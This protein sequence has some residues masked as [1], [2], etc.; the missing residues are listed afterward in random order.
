MGPISLADPD[1]SHRRAYGLAASLLL[2]DFNVGDLIRW[3][4]GAYTHEHIPMEPILTA[5]SAV[6]SIPPPE[7]YPAQDF[8]RALHILEHGAPVTASYECD[9]SDVRLRNAYD[10]HSTI[11]EHA[12]AVREKIISGA[13]NHFLLVLP[14]WIGRFIYGL[15]LSPIGFILRKHKGRIVVDPSTRI[16]S[17]AD[18]GALN[19]HMDKRNTADVPTTF[20]A[21]AQKRHWSHIWNLRASN[22]DTEILLYKDDINSAFHRGRYHPDIAAAFSY[23]WGDWLVISIGLIFGARNSPGWFC[24]LSELRAF[25]ATFYKDLQE[26]PLFQLVSRIVI[27]PAPAPEGP[28]TL[29]PA[30]RDVIN[31]GPVTGSEE[32]THHSTFVDDNLMAELAPRIQLAIQRS[33]AACYLLFGHPRKGILTPSLSEDKFVPAAA[34]HMEQLGFDVDT[35]AMTISYPAPKRSALLEI[36]DLGWTTGSRR[37]HKELAS[38]LGHVRTAAAIVP[39]GSYFS[40]RLQQWLNACMASTTSGVPGNLPYREAHK[41]AWKSKRNYSTPS[42]VARDIAYLRSLLVCPASASIWSRPIGLLVPRVPHMVSCTDASYEGLGGWSTEFDFQWRLS[43]TSLKELGWPVLTKE[44]APFRPLPK[45]MLH[46]N[47]L[48]FIAVFINTWLCMKILSTRT[49]PPGGWVLRLRADNT[50][51]LGWMGHPSR[52]RRDAIQHLARAYAALLTFPLPSSF[53]ITSDH[54]AGVANDAADALSRPQQFP[55]WASTRAKCP[56][57][58][59]LRAFRVPSKLL[60]HLLLSVSCTRTEETLERETTALLKLEPHTLSTGASAS[61]SPTSPSSTPR[62]RQRS[63]SSRRTRS[64]LRKG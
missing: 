44:P 59:S 58:T 8:D 16:H 35:R 51:A 9:L 33:T 54:I 23:V 43:S 7:G 29:T 62:K 53:V 14:R 2:L 10:N 6:R 19:D 49:S 63:K 38:L 1:L 5:I 32:H 46:I 20:Y 42:Q 50:S 31:A 57:L 13:N 45:G 12:A 11:G 52:T 60:S 30:A 18:T 37:T 21:T 56:E 47:V 48:E 28:T 55:T 41:R 27:P 17:D 15:F 3:L 24:V 26:S 4:G 25:I 39:L 61:D 34:W 22:P 40:I 64:R 36:I